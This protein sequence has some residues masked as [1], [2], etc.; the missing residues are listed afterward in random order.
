VDLPRFPHGSGAVERCRR[1]PS[2]LGLVRRVHN[3]L[4]VIL[5]G[6]RRRQR[7][8]VIVGYLQQIDAL[9]G[10][11]VWRRG[12]RGDTRLL[13]NFRMTERQQWLR[14]PSAIHHNRPAFGSST[15]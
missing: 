11:C 15:F 13:I 1:S 14:S 3:A 7:H 12:R 8:A 10:V 2:L 5:V 4:A 9:I 6:H